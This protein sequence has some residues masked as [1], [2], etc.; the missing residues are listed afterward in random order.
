MRKKALKY[1]LSDFNYD[2]PL[3][4]IAQK[5]NKKRDACRLLLLDKKQGNISH[6][7][8]FNLINYL[9]K[10]DLLVLNNS[11]VIPARLL[12]WKKNSGGEIEI[13]L[14]KQ[15]Q[16]NYWEVIVRGRVRENLKIV[17]SLKDISGETKGLEVNL[18]KNNSDGTWL[19]EFNRT[20]KEFWQIINKIGQVPL[21]PYIKRPKGSL[22]DDKLFYQTV[23]ADKKQAGSVAA[24]TA[25]LHFTKNL[26]KKIKQQG[27]EIGEIT[28]H[29]G[30]GTF[31]PIRT[32]DILSHKMH[33]ESVLINSVT[34]KKIEDTKKRGGRI[35]AVGTTVCRALE[36]WAALEKNHHTN[37]FFATDIF[38]YPGYKFKMIDGLITNF[39]LSGSSLLL[40]VSAL[41]GTDKIK[42]SYQIAIKNKYRF[43]S[44][45]D[46]MFIY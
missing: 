29:V 18:I 10:G 12:G 5:P 11:E 21:P 19:V 25:G 35:I 30:L 27:V 13:F 17:F 22:S 46:A 36:S 41:A 15:L 33:S 8:F 32:E 37:K 39:H 3:E 26:L 2:L 6:E 42:K 34:A 43:F 4:L 16:N 38:I 31:E 23:F 24:P 20:D 40:L 28:L 45:G 1:K 7:K 44:Y 9:K 14:H